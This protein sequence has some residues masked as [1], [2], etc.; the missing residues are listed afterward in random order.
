MACKVEGCNGVL[1]KKKK[2]TRLKGRT[3]IEVGFLED[4]HKCDVTVCHKASTERWQ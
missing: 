2:S 3:A 1:K 4:G